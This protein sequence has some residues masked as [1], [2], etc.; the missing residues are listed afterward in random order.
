[1]LIRTGAAF[2]KWAAVVEPRTNVYGIARSL[3][4]VGTLITIVATPVGA[5]FGIGGVGRDRPACAEAIF[6]TLF[7][8]LPLH[9]LEIATWL[10]AILLVVVISGWRPRFTGIIHWWISYSFMASS[11]VLDGGD[12][13]TAIIT[14]L[15][16]PVTL[17]DNR[18]WHWQAAPQVD[19]DDKWSARHAVTVLPALL[20]LTAVRLQVAGIYFQAADAKTRIEEWRDGT[21]LYY[22]FNDP[23]LGA[24]HWMLQWIQSFLSNGRVLTTL[25]WSVVGLEFLLFA[26]LFMDKR[27]R[28]WLLCGGL[29]FHLGIMVVHGLVSFAI[30][31]W[32]ALLLYLWPVNRPICSRAIWTKLSTLIIRTR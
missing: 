3:L 13:V 32:G 6:P 22:W 4:A 10:A 18:R 21:A 16:V 30:A 11:A 23:G 12:Q 1:M 9:Y 27:Y 24:P 15:L 26:G 31:M 25:T 5:L 28:I 20:S 8:E 17:I 19:L 2:R 29:L 7:C 14:L